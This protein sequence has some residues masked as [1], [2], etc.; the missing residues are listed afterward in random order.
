MTPAKPSAPDAQAASD[1]EHWL[2]LHGDALY[3]FAYMRTRDA[4]QAEDLVQETLLAAF[5][6]RGRFAG[7]SSERTWLIAILKNKIV[8]LQRR[9]GREA[10]LPESEDGSEALDALF[11]QR[12]HWSVRPRN[13]GRPHETLENQQFWRVLMECLE[14]LPTRLAEGF[15]LREVEGLSAE[16]VCKVLQV[17]SSNL[18][19][20]LHRARMRLRLCLETQWFSRESE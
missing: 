8:D 3:R 20:S 11:D 6:A 19:V 16:E 15:V 18:W 9:A 7:E 10:P 4:T 17:T 1:P 2:D 13:W 12:D 14:R 5:A